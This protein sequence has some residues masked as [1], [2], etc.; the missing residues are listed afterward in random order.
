MTVLEGFEPRFF[1][2]RFGGSSGI[3]VDYAGADFVGSIDRIDVDAA[4]HAIVI[5]YK[6]KSR[7][8]YDYALADGDGLVPGKLPRHVQALIYAQVVR[9][10]L[11]KMGLT[12]AGAIYLGTAGT[13]ELSGAVPDSMIDRVWGRPLGS[14]AA[15]VTAGLTVSEFTE[16]LD[17][18]EEMIAEAIA[19]MAAGDVEAR[20]VDAAACSWCPVAN[21]ERRL[22]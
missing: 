19:R 10:H 21:C 5:D 2:M 14:R 3:A 16:L 15:R 22:G 17:K 1:E 9:K 8:F 7:L 13:H 12:A 11:D 6:H 18:T 4:G 20:P